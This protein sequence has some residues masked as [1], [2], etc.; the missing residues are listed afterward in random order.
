MDQQQASEK[1][2]NRIRVLLVAEAV[3]LAHVARPVAL[4][5]ALDPGRYDISLACDPRYSHFISN[6][7]WTY[8]P[9]HSISSQQ[10][11]QALATGSPVYNAK[12]LRSYV[13]DDISLIEALKPDLIVGDFR[14]S[15]SVSARLAGIPYMTISN[16]YWSPYSARRDFPL[17]VLP[18]TKF[19]PIPMARFLFALSCRP[20]FAYHAMPLNRVRREYGL[21]SLGTDLRRV[22]TDADYTLYADVP[23]LF[24]T[25]DLPPTHHYLGPVL[26][27]PP[28]PDPAWWDKLPQDRPIVYVTL[29]SSG[30]VERLSDVLEALSNLPVSVMVATAGAEL[31][32]RY[33][34]NVFVADYLPGMEAAARA[35][36]V[37]CNGGSPTSQQALAASVPVLG[38]ACNMDQFLNMEAIARFGAGAVLR[39]DRVTVDKISAMVT[40]MLGSSEYTRAAI[41]LGGILAQYPAPDRF[42]ALVAKVLGGMAS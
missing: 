20:A 8:R 7:Q 23:E 14:L 12:T 29:G 38:V 11:L 1:P 10:F 33:P 30:M 35:D 24:P 26:W 17:P 39:A 37:I 18:M 32:K 22:Y 31:Q 4:G 16:G 27:S 15:L 34:A 6:P 40:R 13:K 41:K 36:L 19:M 21:P 28:V 9:L 3:T 42:A 5:M 25:A 2:L